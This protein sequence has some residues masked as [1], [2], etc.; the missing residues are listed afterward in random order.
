[1]CVTWTS[2]DGSKSASQVMCGSKL[3]SIVTHLPT[4]FAAPTPQEMKY[5]TRIADLVPELY[6]ISL[7]PRSIAHD[8]YSRRTK[9]QRLNT[10]GL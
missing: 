7:G 1:M 9:K 3:P 6:I 10:Y 8:S 5:I 2:L 4:P